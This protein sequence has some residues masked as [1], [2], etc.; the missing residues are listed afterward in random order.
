MKNIDLILE[1]IYEAMLVLS[2]EVEQ[3]EQQAA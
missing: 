2:D 1:A 3:T